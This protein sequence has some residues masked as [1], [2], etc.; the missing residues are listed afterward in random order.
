MVQTNKTTN[1]SSNPLTWILSGES[2][3]EFNYTSQL[4]SPGSNLLSSCWRI[5]SYF[6]SFFAS[7]FEKYSLLSHIWTIFHPCEGF[8]RY[9]KC[10]LTKLAGVIHVPFVWAT[11]FSSEA[12]EK[13]SFVDQMFVTFDIKLTSHA[14]LGHTIDSSIV[15]HYFMHKSKPA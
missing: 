9:W 7:Y 1:N 6:C 2:Y 11:N 10:Y 8:H 4:H 5:N 12:S 14:D 13:E 15:L 3:A